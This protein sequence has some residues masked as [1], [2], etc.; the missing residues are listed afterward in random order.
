MPV[1][2]RRV[3]VRLPQGCLGREQAGTPAN[4]RLGRARPS[5]RAPAEEGALSANGR[6]AASFMSTEQRRKAAFKAW[7]T[8]RRNAKTPASAEAK[9]GVEGS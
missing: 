3:G 2:D 8:K 4:R 1:W 9:T 6:K 7:Q 5:G